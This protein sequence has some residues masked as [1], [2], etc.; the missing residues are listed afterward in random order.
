MKPSRI[1]RLWPALGALALL[2][3][4]AFVSAAPKPESPYG[5]PFDASKD[6]HRIDWLIQVTGIFV[7]VLFVIMVVWMFWAC[8]KHNKNHTAEYDHGN[9][10]HS[11]KVAFLISAV[12]FFVVD[13]NLWY[14]STV[15]VSNAFWN[16]ED[17][18]KEPGLVRIE[19]N[20]HQWLWDARY[21]GPDE[22]FGTQDDIVTTNDI[23]VPVGAPVLVQLASVDVIHSFY[24]P[25]F[26]VK[27]DAVPGSITRLLFEA[28]EVGEYDIACAQHC[29]VHH[30]KMG[31]TLTVLSPEE[32]QE[33]TQRASE[34][35]ARDFD[36][37][38]P[39]QNWA[40]AWEKI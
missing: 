22:T 19:V 10:K 25:N 17:A 6:G 5:L 36:P 3:L 29:G 9:S 39:D 23:R 38:S 33:W 35:S 32:Y 20:A 26:R 8:I 4:P 1:R 15:D 28:K 7:I 27:I 11:I 21:A 37:K 12:I 30:Y 14:N 24:L 16:Y 13:G 40:W 31:A 2:V 34:M 18:Y